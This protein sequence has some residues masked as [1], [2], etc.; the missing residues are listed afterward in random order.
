MTANR[1]FALWGH[2]LSVRF[3]RI[4]IAESTLWSAT[5]DTGKPVS[6]A[7]DKYRAA[8]TRARSLSFTEFNI[9]LWAGSADTPYFGPGPF[10]LRPRPLDENFWTRLLRRCRPG[11]RRRLPPRPQPLGV[12]HHIDD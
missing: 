7:S 9:R 5:S 4:L 11:R 1:L 12:G 8:I 6:Y 2:V 3:L 10:A